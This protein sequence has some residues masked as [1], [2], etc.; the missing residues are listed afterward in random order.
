MLQFVQ[1][2]L[3]I[4]VWRRADDSFEGWAN[5]GTNGYDDG[6][7]HVRVFDPSR[8]GDRPLG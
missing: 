6:D 7:A 2:Y 8:K 1:G 3:W 4:C 5:A